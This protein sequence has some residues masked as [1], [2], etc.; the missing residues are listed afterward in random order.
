MKEISLPSISITCP[1]RIAIYHLKY[2]ILQ[3]VLKF[4]ILAGQLQTWLIWSN[5]LLVSCWYKW[6]SKVLNLPVTFH[7]WKGCFW[8]TLMYF[9][10]FQIQ[11][12]NLLSP[13]FCF[14][15]CICVCIFLFVCVCMCCNVF[16]CVAVFKWT[17][18]R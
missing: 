5:V 6:K 3:L 17:V 1:I 15:I 11:L 12:M 10:T 7:Y 9:I 2:F 8:N 18:F 16:I 14:Y 13:S 4:Y